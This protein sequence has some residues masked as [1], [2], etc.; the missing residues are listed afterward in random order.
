MKYIFT[1]I[2]AA[3]IVSSCTSIKEHN[4]HI[5]DLISENDLKTDV[6]YIYGRLQKMHPKLYWYISKEKLDYKFD[7]LKMT[8]SKPMKSFDFYKKLAPVIKTIG[9][10][11]MNVTPYVKKYSIEETKQLIKKGVSPFSQFEYEMIDNKIY[12]VKNKSYNKKIKVGTEIVGINGENLIDL[13]KKYKTCFASDGFNT[14]FL[15]RRLGKNFAGFYTYEHGIQ[16]S[17]TF[18]FKTNDS[19]KNVFFKTWNCRFC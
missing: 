17:L 10:G 8:L 15:S 16:D 7:S 9:E 19:I 1:L 5:D 6:D 14:T 3:T 4:A 18:N 12:I 2:I 11:H 13:T